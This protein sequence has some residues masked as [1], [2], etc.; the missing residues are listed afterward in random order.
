MFIPIPNLQA[1]FWISLIEQGSFNKRY[2][3]TEKIHRK[4]EENADNNF[5]PRL[6]AFYCK[7]QSV[8]LLIFS[9]NITTLNVEYKFWISLE[10]LENTGE[11]EEMMKF[12]LC[13]QNFSE[14]WI[15]YLE[16]PW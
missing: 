1:N 9:Q 15:Y 12:Y 7:V 14:H 13:L 3:G 4:F 11:K 16:F 5:I 6:F 10:T 2:V 8:W